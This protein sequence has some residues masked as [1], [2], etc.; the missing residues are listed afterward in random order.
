MF[1]GVIISRKIYKKGSLNS[2]LSN[3]TFYSDANETNGIM[4]DFVVG[5]LCKKLYSYKQ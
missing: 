2:N 4:W 1:L 5:Y 3:N